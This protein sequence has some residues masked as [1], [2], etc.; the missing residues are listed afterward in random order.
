MFGAET[1][2]EE[3]QRHGA[4][5]NGEGIVGAGDGVRRRVGGGFVQGYYPAEGGGRRGRGFGV[6]GIGVAA[7][8][9]R[10]GGAVCCY[11]GEVSFDRVRSGR[12]GGGVPCCGIT[13]AVAGTT[14]FEFVNI[15]SYQLRKR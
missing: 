10:V 7:P 14:S 3:D 6:G 12:E 15:M 13:R 5:N 11:A 1:G 2:V 4:E 8:G 9:G